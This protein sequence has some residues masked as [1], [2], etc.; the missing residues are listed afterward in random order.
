MSLHG[1]E[2]PHRC[3]VTDREKSS[4]TVESQLI[5]LFLPLI[6]PLSN[7]TDEGEEFS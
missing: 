6:V 3:V 7:N 5:M 2:E 4:S 1:R